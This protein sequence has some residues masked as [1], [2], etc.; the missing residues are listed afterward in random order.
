M[1]KRFFS[2]FS[3]KIMKDYFSRFNKG[4]PPKVLDV[5]QVTLLCNLLQNPSNKNFKIY[6]ENHFLYNQFANR[7]VP[8]VD[9][10]SLL[11]AQLL[12]N[13][14]NNTIYSPIVNKKEAIKLLGTMQGGYNVNILI[15]L[16]DNDELAELASNELSKTILIFDS[17][18]EVEKK[19]KKVNIYA[20]KLILDWA[21]AKWF[22]NKPKVPEK[23]DVSVFKVSGEINTDDLSPAQDAWSRPDI[24]LHALSMLKVPR[25]GIE[26]DEPYEVGPIKL[27]NK[28]KE[29]GYP[30]AFVGDIVGTGPSRKSATNSLLWH[31]G[32]DINYVPNKKTGGICIGSKIAPIFYNTMEDSGALPIE[33]NVDKLN[34]GDVVSIYPY[35]GETFCKNSGVL[36]NKFNLKSDTLLDSVQAG[37]RNNL[38]I[39][40]SLTQKAQDYYKKYN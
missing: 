32:E 27:I 36:L 31:F 29:N 24:P 23:I 11:K 8:G 17:S 12:S 39:G 15:D 14:C 21:D 19:A 2:G 28:I 40:K 9:E 18:Y 20:L 16:L 13:I 5:Q 6:E 22:L 37:G 7:I 1:S 30:V 3:D 38:I 35:N 34:M 25:S 10:T 33:M 4:I 26:P